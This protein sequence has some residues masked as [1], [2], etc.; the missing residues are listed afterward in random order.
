MSQH[1]ILNSADHLNLRVHTEAGA[2]YGDD[3]MA[4]LTVPLEFRQVQARFPIVFRRDIETGKLSALAL[5]GFENGEN[6]YFGDGRDDGGYR[7]LALAIH[8]FLIGRRAT[9]GGDAQV[10]I[11]MGHPRVSTNGEGVR[12]FD[13]DGRPTPYLDS[14]AEKLGDLDY[15]YQLSADFFSALEAY[16]LVEPFS[17]D[18]TLDHGSKQSLVGFQTINEDRFATLDAA[19][20]HQLHRQG[21][22]LPI[23]MVLAS[24]TQF[25]ELVA[26]KKARISGG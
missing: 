11:D 9:E 21:H 1:Q 20:L 16:G 8:P 25:G 15:G 24:L 13:E 10:H 23:F 17:F 18:V 7:P 4:C 19:A 5:M 26:R 14:I 2:A 22:L 6:L 3:V 12:V